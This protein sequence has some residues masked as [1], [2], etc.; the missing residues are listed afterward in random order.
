[1]FRR[2]ISSSQTLAHEEILTS[3]INNMPSKR[4]F[5]DVAIGAAASQRIM[6]EL[7]HDR[8]PRTVE[9]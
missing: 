6:F 1:M 3:I 4:T 2:A 5:M 9:K 8:V 7:D